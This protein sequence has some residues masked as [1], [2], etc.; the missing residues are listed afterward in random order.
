LRRACAYAAAENNGSRS[1]LLPS[2]N[3]TSRAD[4]PAEPRQRDRPTLILVSNTEPTCRVGSARDRQCLVLA[5]PKP[6]GHAVKTEGAVLVSDPLP[7]EVPQTSARHAGLDARVPSGS[8]ATAPTGSRRGEAA[9]TGAQGDARA[10]GWGSPHRLR[11]ITAV[12][13]QAQRRPARTTIPPTSNAI[14]SAC[15][16]GDGSPSKRWR[17]LGPRPNFPPIGRLAAESVNRLLRLGRGRTRP[18]L[19]SQR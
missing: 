1:V 4:A 17:R 13:E 15:V 7:T 11:M 5:A 8:T 16:L 6:A 9:D 19:R 3:L 14:A 2:L 12:P 18:V 10:A